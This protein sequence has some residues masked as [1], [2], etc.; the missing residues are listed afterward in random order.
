[1]NG[2]VFEMTSPHQAHTRTSVR[3]H[4]SSPRKKYEEE[5]DLV[6]HYFYL[7]MEDGQDTFMKDLFSPD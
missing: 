2:K 7:F 5:L 3:T 6:G 4:T 1:M